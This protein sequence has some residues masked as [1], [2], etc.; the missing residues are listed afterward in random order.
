ML[1]YI[2]LIALGGTCNTFIENSD[3][4]FCLHVFFSLT[5]LTAGAMQHLVDSRK[6]LVFNPENLIT[7]AAVFEKEHI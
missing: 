5:T 6:F 2:D 7:F 1:E 4:Q 3:E